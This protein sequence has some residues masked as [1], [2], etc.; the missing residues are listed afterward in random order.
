MRLRHSAR[1]S[2]WLG[3]RDRHGAP[4]P[5][6]PE[7]L[8]TGEFQVNAVMLMRSHLGGGPARYE[9][10]SEVPLLVPVAAGAPA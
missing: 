10:L 6:L 5:P 2:R 7:G 3:A 9:A 8:P 4:L 1:T